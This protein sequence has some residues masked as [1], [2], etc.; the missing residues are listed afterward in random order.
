MKE[1]I[2]LIGG[3]GHCKVVINAIK[4]EA[5]FDIHGILDTGLAK[6]ASVLGVPVIGRDDMLP[7]LSKQLKYAFIAFGSIG[8]CEARKKIYADLKNNGLELPFI[9]HPDAVVAEDV[10]VEEGTFIAAGVVINP[11]TRIGKNAIINTNSSVDHDCKIGDFVHIAPGVTLSGGVEVKNEV[12]IGTG[13]K[14]IQNVCV[15]RFIPAASLAYKNEDGSLAI[16]SPKHH[17]DSAKMT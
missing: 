11:G 8:N 4:N 15:D 16:T 13:A 3:G 17:E 2:V 7:E 1:R 6:G 9:K 14:V 10:E 5:K 12:H